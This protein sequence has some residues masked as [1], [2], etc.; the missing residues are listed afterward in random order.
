MS[1]LK[2]NSKLAGIILG[3][4]VIGMVY[5]IWQNY[6]FTQREINKLIQRET[7][8]YQEILK[9]VVKEK[10]IYIIDFGDGNINSYQIV[11]SEDSTV[12]SLLEELAKREGFEVE[13]KVYEEMGVFVESIAGFKGGTDNKWWQYWVNG[14]LPMVAADKRE[15]K[16]GDKVEWRFAPPPF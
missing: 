1:K 6:L 13:S 7:A 15:L 2:V 9:P 11:L 16:K 3:I 5:L 10:V 4:L 8:T 14:E 12:F